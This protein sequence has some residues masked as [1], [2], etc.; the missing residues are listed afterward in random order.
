MTLHDSRYQDCIEFN[1]DTLQRVIILFDIY[2]WSL[3][4]ILKCVCVYE[5]LQS[6]VWYE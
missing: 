3:L 2:R 6:G 4:A 5:C 1:G